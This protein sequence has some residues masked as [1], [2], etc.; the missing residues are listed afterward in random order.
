MFKNFKL[1]PALMM[2]I[3]HTAMAQGSGD[4]VSVLSVSRIAINAD[5]KEI[6]E[7]A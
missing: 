3:A 7:P 4:I 5:G 2:L 1:L 6:A